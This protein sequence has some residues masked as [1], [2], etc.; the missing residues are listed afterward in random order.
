MLIHKEISG[1]MHIYLSNLEENKSKVFSGKYL[2]FSNNKEILLSILEK[3]ITEHDFVKGKISLVNA[4]GDNSAVLCLYWYDDS[5][6][7]E[8]SLRHARKV[9]WKD[10]N[11]TDNN[12]YAKSFGL[13]STTIIELK[14][15]WRKSRSYCLSY[16]NLFNRCLL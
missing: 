4:K 2:F 3:E 13:D 6:K 8:L 9:M 7:E 10:D 14:M 16:A 11:D 12:K 5:R 1:W 15:K